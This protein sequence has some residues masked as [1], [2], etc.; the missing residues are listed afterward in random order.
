MHVAG[1]TWH[2]YLPA[3]ASLTCFLFSLHHFTCPRCLQIHRLPESPRCHS[4]CCPPLE[5]TPT[6]SYVLL[7]HGGGDTHLLQAQRGTEASF[8]LYSFGNFTPTPR[9]L[10]PQEEAEHRSAPLGY[11]RHPPFTVFLSAASHFPSVSVHKGYH[12]RVHS[13]AYIQQAPISPTSRSQK[14][15]VK[16]STGLVSPEAPFFGCAWPPSCHPLAQ[17]SLWVCLCLTLFS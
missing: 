8:S 2:P 16:V 6:H 9:T 13:L 4:S 11:T 14:S 7:T 17:S 3:W 12:N 15:K 10:F 5:E 1:G